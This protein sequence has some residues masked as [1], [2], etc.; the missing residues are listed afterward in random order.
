MRTTQDVAVTIAEFSAELTYERL[1]SEVVSTLKRIILDTLGTTLAA[2][3]LGVGCKELVSVVRMAGGTQESTL[4]GIG[5]KVPAIM[6]ALANGGMS[7]ALNYDDTAGPRGSGHLGVTSLPA[8]LAA[9]EFAGDVSGKE[10]LAAVA[11]GT[12]LMSRLGLAISG[13]EVGYTESKPQPTQMPGC[14]SAAVAASRVLG[15]DA[16]GV[17]SALGHALMQASG[18]R[19]PVLEGRPSKAIYAAY[20]NQVGMLSA[21][22]SRA[23]LR[24]D[25]AVFE[26]EAGLFKTYYQGRYVRSALDS[27]WG[28]EFH[29]LNVGFKPWPTTGVA[30]PFIDA[31]LQLLEAHEVDPASIASVQIRGGAHSRTFCE[32]EETRKRPQSPVEAEDSIYFSVAK[33]LANRR[34]TLGDLQPT[35]DGLHQPEALA[36]TERTHLTVEE[37]LERSG[38]VEITMADGRQFSSRVDAAL[39]HPSNPLPYDRLVEKFIDCARYAS[40]EV[41]RSRL[42]EVVDLVDHLERVPNVAVLPGLLSG[43]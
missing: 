25:C 11:A 33:A 29:L 34:V 3:T 39:G 16:L 14:F 28:E 26:G 20:S 36:L 37:G 43:R 24:G 32:P 41:P 6:A 18:G 17:H 10:L 42:D 35:P 1:P 23:G 30:H 9:A 7:H 22:L 19:Q 13:A 31:S 8:A 40:T 21:M 4:I 15:F 2:N 27:G 12:E 38:I 5:E